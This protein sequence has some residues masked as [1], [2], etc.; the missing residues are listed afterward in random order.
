MLRRTNDVRTL[1]TVPQA[2]DSP[3]DSIFEVIMY[4]TPDQ[5]VALQKAALE[6]FQAAA[7]KSF[8]G[9]Q[10]L[11]DLNLAVFRST[12][13]ESADQFRAVFEAKDPKAFAN[14]AAVSAQ[15]AAEK[16]SA[17]AKQVYAIASDVGGELAKLVEK[18]V[19]DGNR[20]MFAAIDAMAK[21]AP[22]GSEG[23]VTFIKS[24]V[25][26]A[27]SAYDQVQ[28]ATKQAVELAEANFAAAGKSAVNGAARA[29]KA[30]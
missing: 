23:V 14:L 26:S 20:Q 6:S 30:A 1:R 15:P 19:A 2:S 13:E 27:N 4:A 16:A 18:Q 10:K 25:S 7:A 8:E 22:A 3:T 12:V 28:K 24:A 11:A 5:F 17:Y 29:K 9:A 21:N